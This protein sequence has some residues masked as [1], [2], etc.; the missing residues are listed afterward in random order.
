MA[1]YRLV[2]PGWLPAPLNQLTG[3]QR[4]AA[5]LKRRDRNRIRF[6]FFLSGIPKAVTKRRVS[7]EVTYLKGERSHDPDAFWKALF[8]GLV[9]A[10]ALRND[11]RHWVV[12]GE[13]T[14]ARAERHQTTIT[15]EDL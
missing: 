13:V 6:Y 11:S 12:Q 4:K 2:I 15:L 9:H 5:R 1:V 14:Y 7:I 3:N 10:G 8:D